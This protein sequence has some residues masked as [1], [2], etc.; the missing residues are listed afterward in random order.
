[1]VENGLLS[2]EDAGVSLGAIIADYKKAV[3]D[4]TLALEVSSS[5][6]E[7]M[8]AKQGYLMAAAGVI[9]DLSKIY[10]IKG[11]CKAAE[12]FEAA[13][14]AY[15]DDSDRKAFYM[16][17]DGRFALSEDISRFL[18]SRLRTWAYRACGT[19][20]L[21]CRELLYSN[22]LQSSFLR[23]LLDVALE[24]PIDAWDCAPCLAAEGNCR[25][26]GY[27]RD[28]IICAHSGSTYEML[29]WSRGF[30][31][32]SARRALAKVGVRAKAYQGEDLYSGAAKYSILNQEADL[33]DG[34][35]AVDLC[36]W[37]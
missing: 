1:M 10:N 2:Q 33:C 37:S 27:G 35:D 29:S 4:F 13:A 6:Y 19:G 9:E 3:E 23:F 36:D 25:D 16:G 22:D 21:Y 34:S 30:I 28:H 8:L 18:K 26:C 20:M 31:I 15:L 11:L 24:L 5:V 32:R 14:M 12:F 7:I 17:S